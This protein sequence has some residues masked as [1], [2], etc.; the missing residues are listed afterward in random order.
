MEFCC[1]ADN[2]LN[3]VNKFVQLVFEVT[4][5][6]IIPYHYAVVTWIHYS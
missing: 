5:L 2:E 6:Y 1:S 3:D 4:Y